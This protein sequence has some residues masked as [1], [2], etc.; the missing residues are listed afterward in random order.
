[1]AKEA[2]PKKKVD[3]YTARVGP[4]A[5]MRRYNKQI[6]VGAGVFLMIAF[7]VP[8]TLQKLGR[9]PSRRIMYYLGDE[10]IR[11]SFHGMMSRKLQFIERARGSIA[12][13]V[14]AAPEGSQSQQVLIAAYRDIAWPEQGFQGTEAIGGVDHWLLLAKAAEDGGFIG[15]IQRGEQF[16]SAP[17]D[18]AAHEQLQ[19][20]HNRILAGSGLTEEE[21]GR[22]LA[23]YRG[24]LDMLGS[25]EHAARLSSARLI[26]HAADRADAAVVDLVVVPPSHV[27]D[28][29][30][31]PTEQELADLCYE[32]RNEQPG[33]GTYG[34]GYRQPADVKYEYLAITRAE[35]EASADVDRFEAHKYFLQHRDEF[36]PEGADPDSV[37]YATVRD[38]VVSL[39]RSRQVGTRITEIERSVTD[40]ITRTRKGLVSENGFFILPDDWNQ[41][42]TDFETVAGEIAEEY[43]I[44]RPTVERREADWMPIDSIEQYTAALA[45]E[46][47]YLVF[48]RER[49]FFKEILASLRE[50]APDEDRAFQ[51]GVVIGP[52]TDAFGTSY[53][54]RATAARPERPAMTDVP[55]DAADSAVER[56]AMWQALEARVQEQVRVDARN[57]RAFDILTA[58]LDVWRELA[59]TE[60][61]DAVATRVG[62]DVRTN[63]S[64]TRRAYQGGVPEIPEVGRDDEFVAA[65]Q[66]VI[67]PLDP[68]ADVSSLDSAQRIVV[69]AIPGRQEIA[70]ALVQRRSP[71]T[72]DTYRFQAMFGLVDSILRDEAETGP[73]PFSFDALAARYEYR[74]A[75]AR[76]RQPEPDGEGVDQ[77]GADDE[78]SP[79]ASS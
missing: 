79:A 24:V 60:G 57:L 50:V 15:S 25:Y 8:G 73:K 74:P 76:A 31:Q 29:I 62:T 7:L 53:F 58:Q 39:I 34:F 35:V 48:G 44:P 69:R 5:F 55:E 17:Q 45:I 33:S 72:V 27:L 16:F 10:A 71:L 14:A 1:M 9:N 11:G 77:A 26:K 37:E 56:L 30:A 75:H 59:V 42:R 78:E 49:M 67:E 63:I 43:G 23:A 66:A 61:L 32:Y 65:V 40:E 70:I 64:V 52:L 3:Q 54:L 2:K 12:G 41:L 6:M 68:E 36:T 28:A 13:G 21:A 19:R 38:D 4:L 46:G 20:L 22:A 51:V 47:S 18:D